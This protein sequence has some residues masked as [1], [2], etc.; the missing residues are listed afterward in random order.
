[1]LKNNS[2]D[3][4]MQKYDAVIVGAGIAGLGVA[5]LL[6]KSG[7]KTLVLEK[8]K[9]PGGRAK[10]REFPGGWRVD[11]GTHC[12]D[13]GEKSACAE[14]LRRVGKE[15]TWTRGL[16]GMMVYDDGKWLHI[17]DYL[18]LSDGEQRDLV[19]LED[20]FAVMTEEQIDILDKMSLAEFIRK[21]ISSPKVAEYFK[22]LG[23]IQSTLTEAEIISAGEFVAIYSEGMKYGGRWGSLG[24]VRMPLGGIGVMTKALADGATGA[25]AVIE[26]GK[27][28]DKISV[29]KN[30]QIRVFVGDSEYT[31]P[32]VVLALPIWQMVN[33][34]SAE[35][36][37]VPQKWLDS[38]RGLVDETSAS[39]GFTMGTKKPLFTEPVY[40]S[41]WRLADVGLP[42]QI[43][44]QT[45]FDAT[46]A[47][48]GHMIAFIGTPCKPQQA[49]DVKFREETLAKF[50]ETVKKMFPHVEENVVWKFDGY[51]VGIDGLARS[52]GL[53]GKYRPPVFLQDVPGLYFAGDCYTGRGVGM[54]AAANSAMI[55]AEKIQ[56]DFK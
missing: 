47:P 42:L 14:L 27:P 3:L 11:S 49:R 38:M 39:I 30:G 12:V 16:E 19:S 54:N 22:I 29:N 23:M 40:L 17:Q 28:V 2:K 52:P 18:N 9:S 31:A 5:G 37:S 36:N 8:S 6:Q 43:L 25:G 10:T 51:Y 26:Y 33:L 53:T 21:N 55:C 20:S 44:G 7:I 56:T 32:A 45:N 4:K 24:N 50:W 1:L 35:D 13:H 46:I 34:F 41:A 48:P 15:I